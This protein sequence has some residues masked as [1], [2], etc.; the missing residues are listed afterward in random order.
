MSNSPESVLSRERRD[1]LVLLLAWAAGS[2]D[3]IAYL[4]LDH[5]FT[6]NM[7]GNMVLLGL[8]LGQGQGLAAIANVIALVAFILGLIIGAV[9]VAKG[10]KQGDWDRRVTWAL[11]WEGMMIAA[12]TLVWHVTPAGEERGSAALYLLIALSAMAMGV[13][14]VAVRHLNIPAVS[15]TYVT[16][17]M[18]SLIAALVSRLRSSSP[19]TRGKEA[20]E[21]TLP[22]KHQVKLQAGVL[23]TYALSA[24]ASGLFQMRV[25]WLVAVTPLFAVAL[26]LLIVSFAHRQHESRREAE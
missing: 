18:T 25:P 15:T 17:T 10:G 21:E 20:V 8:T 14:S 7:T 4:G 12:F 23:V 22:W 5:V 19:K 11:F 3:A 13:Q 24:V 2:L 26:V 9:I 6:A 1:S 16:G